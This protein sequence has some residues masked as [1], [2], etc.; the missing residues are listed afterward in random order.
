MSLIL[1]VSALLEPISATRL[2]IQARAHIRVWFGRHGTRGW[3]LQPCVYRDGFALNEDDRQ[4]KKR[5]LTHDF[6]AQRASAQRGC[7]TFQPHGA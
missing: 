3:A 6:V 2:A 4:R 5:H 1:S 7:F